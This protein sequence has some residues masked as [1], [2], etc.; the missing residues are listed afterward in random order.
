MAYPGNMHR[1]TQA[2]EPIRYSGPE[3]WPLRG[4]T[5]LA[6]AVEHRI[7]TLLRHIKETYMLRRWDGGD[8]RT[9][10]RNPQ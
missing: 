6:I 2:A 9:K 3:Y 8:S 10:W 4:S 5:A 1:Y 7:R